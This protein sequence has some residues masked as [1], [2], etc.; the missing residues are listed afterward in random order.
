LAIKG[1]PLTLTLASFLKDMHCPAVAGSSSG[2]HR[3]QSSSSTVTPSSLFSQ[4]SKK[5]PQ[6]R[7][8]QQQD[9]HE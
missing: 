4:I 9:A 2:K 5:S 1:K 7:G 8:S 3:R 6:F